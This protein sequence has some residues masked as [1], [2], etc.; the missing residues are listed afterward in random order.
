MADRH[1]NVVVLPGRG[2]VGRGQA[3]SLEIA[4]MAAGQLDEL[5]HHLQQLSPHMHW[6]ARRWMIASTP[7]RMRLTGAR[8]GLSELCVVSAADGQHPGRSALELSDACLDAERRLHDIDVC[9]CKLLQAE[10]PAAERTRAAETFASGRSGLLKVFW[11]IQQLVGQRLPS[12]PGE[13]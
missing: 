4:R 7:F 11:E 13:N 10:T 2:R 6:S 1:D 9:L 12:V 3:G 5:S 8:R